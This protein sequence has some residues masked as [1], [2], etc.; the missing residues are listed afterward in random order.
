MTLRFI[1]LK[2]K[3]TFRVFEDTEHIYKHA[4]YIAVFLFSR[5][6]SRNSSGDI[7]ETKQNEKH[8]KG[9]KKHTFYHSQAK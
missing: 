8:K 1:Q 7:D 2:K 3:S 9:C 4:F 5:K 6:N